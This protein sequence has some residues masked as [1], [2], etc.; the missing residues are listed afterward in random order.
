VF[1]SFV[2][3]VF[4]IFLADCPL[5]CEEPS[6]YY[7]RFI[8]LFDF[9][10]PRRVHLIRHMRKWCRL[11]RIRVRLFLLFQFGRLKNLRDSQVKVFSCFLGYINT[12]FQTRYFGLAIHTFVE[13]GHEFIITID[14]KRSLRL[15]K[16]PTGLTQIGVVLPDQL[17]LFPHFCKELGYRLT[18]LKFDSLFILFIHLLSFCFFLRFLFLLWYLWSDFLL[19]FVRF[20][21]HYRS[22]WREKSLWSILPKRNLLLLLPTRFLLLFLERL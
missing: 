20:F 13:F 4:G 10:P 8:S 9:L 17:Q 19:N 18:Y 12:Q 15:L 2:S 11:W 16:A 5:I 22:L 3:F 1:W 7:R 14:L 6:F 21:F